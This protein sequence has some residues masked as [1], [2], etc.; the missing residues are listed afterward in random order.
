MGVFII[1]VGTALLFKSPS[2]KIP[3]KGVILGLVSSFFFALNACFDRLAATHGHPIYSGFLMTLFAA[4][5]LL[6]PS[7]KLK[8][9][10][11]EIKFSI[12]PLILRGFFESTHMALKLAAYQHLE[13]QYASGISKLALVLSVVVGGSIFKEQDRKLRIISSIIIALGS[14]IITLTK[15]FD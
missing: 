6:I 8:A 9:P 7:L 2:T 13:P 14:L 1:F 11:A 15:I 12:I 4:L 5:I 10:I 3:W